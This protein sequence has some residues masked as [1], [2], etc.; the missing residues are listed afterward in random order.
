[1]GGK[2]F[3]LGLAWTVACLCQC[4][5]SPQ[6]CPGWLIRLVAQPGA[7]DARLHNR[8]LRIRAVH[9]YITGIHTRAHIASHTGHALHLTC[10]AQD[11]HKL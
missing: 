1:M 11:A 4:S 2:R 6:E 9:I 3:R 10:H 7:T 5:S 8:G